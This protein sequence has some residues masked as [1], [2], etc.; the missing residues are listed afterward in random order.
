MKCPALN[1][2]G[3]YFGSVKR[4]IFNGFKENSRVLS[5]CFQRNVLK[6][7]FYDD[8]YRKVMSIKAKNSSEIELAGV[9]SC[10]D[11]KGEK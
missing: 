7:L 4:M 6:D 1:F 3:D 2:Q 5:E 8:E 9:V 10:L 11:K